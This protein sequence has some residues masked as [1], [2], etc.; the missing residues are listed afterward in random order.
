MAVCERES[1]VTALF[2]PMIDPYLT[3]A[4]AQLLDFMLYF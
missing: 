3:V 2:A 4:Y 1:A